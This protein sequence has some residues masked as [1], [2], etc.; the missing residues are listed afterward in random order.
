MS[1][2]QPLL[3]EFKQEKDLTRKILERVPFDRP[4]WK[5]HEKSMT[6]QRLASHI[7]ELPRWMGRT[8]ESDAFDLAAITLE[9]FHAQDNAELL[10]KYQDCFTEAYDLLAG[11]SDELLLGNWSMKRGDQAVC[12]Q[13]HDSSPRTIVCL[14]ETAGCSC[15]RDVR[16]ERG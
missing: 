1:L 12:A 6:I 10:Q 13:P 5:P 2:N 3:A 4:Q 14:F 7:S 9:R 15:S 11:A 8:L 16:T